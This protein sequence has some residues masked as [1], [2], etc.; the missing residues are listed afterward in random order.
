MTRIVTSTAVM[1]AIILGLFGSVH[2][3]ASDPVQTFIGHAFDTGLPLIMT[4]L[5]ALM[6]MGTL[7]RHRVRRRLPAF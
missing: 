3:M 4:A 5:A 6:L 7:N 2:L 1:A